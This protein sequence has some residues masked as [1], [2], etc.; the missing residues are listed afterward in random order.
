MSQGKKKRKG[1]RQRSPPVLEYLQ[2]I[3]RKYPDGGQILKEL[4]QNADDA[5]AEEVILFY[6]DRSFGTQRLFS[7][8]L[9]STQGPALLA[10][11]NGIFSEADWKG[12]ESPGI[13][14]KKKDPM[15]VGRFGL[16]F[17][18]VYHMTDFPSILSGEYLL[19]LDTQATALEDGGERWEVDEWEDATDQFQPFWDSLASLGKPCPTSEGYFPGTLFRFPLRQS[20]SK[21]SENLYSTER[22]RELLL[23]FLNDAPISLLFLRNVRKVT[24]GLIGSDGTIT[25]LLR[26]ETTT[27]PLNGPGR[28]EDATSA[29]LDTTAH[30]KKLALDGTTVDKQAT[31]NEWLVLTAEAKRDAYPEL[32]VLAENVSSSPTLSLAYCLQGK[33][34]GRLSC[35]LPLPATEENLTGLPAH[36]SGP[37]QLTDDRRHVQ[38]S[39]EGSQARG[40]DGRWNHLL[41]EEMLPA[42]YCQ[43]ALQAV[44][45]S[46]DPYGAWP[47]PGQSQQ[48]RYKPLIAEICR[49][50]MDVKLLV[51]VGGGIPR[52]LHPREAIL[53][54]ENVKET[55]MGLAVEK[56]LSLAGT[57]LAE[58]PVHVRRALALGA[59]NGPTV[60]E[61]TTKFVRET[62]R[63]ATNIWSQLSL[64]EKK[65]LLEYVVGDEC[66]QELNGLPLLPMT[67]GHFTCFGASGETVFVEN[68]SFPRVL[69]PGLAHRFLP[70]NLNPGLLEHLKAIAKNGIFQNLLSLNQNIIEQNLR[71]SLPKHWFSSSSSPVSWCPK[72]YSQPP[73]EWLTAFWSFLSRHTPSLAP[74]RECPLIP[75]TP[76][77]ASDNVIKLARLLPQ[78]T[79]LFQSHNGHSLPNEV[80]GILEAL[81][82]TVIKTWKPDWC[83]QQLREYI[84]EPTPSSVLKVFAH[85]GVASV[86][87]CLAF[88]PEWQIQSLSAFLS[89]AASLSQKEIEVL[90][91][92]PLFFKMPSLLPPSSPGLVPA[93]G[94]LALEKHLVPSVPTDL[95][96]PEPVLLC[97]SEAERRL[98][99]QIQGSL[100]D[101]PDLCLLCVKAMGKGAYASRAQDAKRF[102]L[103]VLHNG[104]SLF[105]QSRELQALC[106]DL[107][108][109]DCE[110]GG[111][112]RP[113]DLYDPQNHTLRALLRSSKF[114]A[115]P[116]LE[117]AVLRILRNLGLK[118][119][120][121]SISPADAL[122]AAKE[123]SQLQ[124]EVVA[125][126]K[127]QA[128]I[129]V[130]NETP[131]LSKLSCRE[132]KELRS[133]LWVPAINSSKLV[134]AG[135]FWAPESLCSE[136]YA[137]LVGLV[138][139]LTNAFCP[140]AASKLGLDHPPASEKV[141]EN[142]VC[143]TQAYCP[144]NTQ[145]L[146]TTLHSIYRHMQQHLSDFKTPPTVPSVWNGRGFS[147]PEEAVLSYPNGLDLKDLIPQVPPE[148]QQNSRLFVAWGV[149]Q[150]PTPEDVCQALH[151]LADQINAQPQG[152]TQA[153]LLLVTAALDWLC[154]QDHRGE[155]EMPVPVR[156]PELAG[157]A[158]RPISSV[159]YCDMDRA[160]LVELDGDPP[161]LVHELV[162]SATA[163]F[164]GIEM[165][166]KRLSGL[167]LFEAWG[168]S[169]P[170]TLRIRNILREYSQDAD[171]FQELLQNAEDA[172]A[173]TCR[174]LVDVRQHNGTTEGLLDPGMA[175]CQGPALWAQNDALFSKADFTNIVQLGAATKERQDDKIGS[176]GLGFCTVYH[177]TDIPSL[178]SGHTMLIFDPNVTHLQKHIRSPA[179]PG[180]RLTLTPHV[181]TM[182]PEQ[183]RP[184]GGIFGCRPGED[185]S[186]TLLRLPFRTEQEAKD[187]QICPEPFGPRRIR[188]LQ[189]GFREMYQHLLIFLRKVQE[190][191]LTHLPSGSS[192]PE[193]AQP[194]ATVKREKLDGMGN[195]N[196][197]RLTATWESEGV[198][199]YYLLHSCSAK[200]E[201]QELF[202]QGGKEGLHFSPPI[203]AVAL[204]LCPATAGGRWVPGVHGFQGR[205]FCF[206]PLPIESGLP[207]HLTAAFA[208]LSNRKGLW[209]ATEKGKWNRALLRDSVLGAWLGALSQLRDL[210]K[211]GLL[212]DYKYYTFWPDVRSAKHPFSEAAKAFYQALINGIDGEQ[213]VL[214]SDGK[215]WCPARHA[216]ILAAD[217]ICEKQ[218][219]PIAA[220]IFPLLLPEPQIAVSL[221]SWVETNFEACTQADVLLPNT[222]TWAR[223]LRELVLPNLAQLEAPDRDALLLRALDMNDATVDKIL[224]SLPC[225]PTTPKALL[226]NI[227]GLVHPGGPV[228]PLYTPEDGRFPM[229][230]QFVQPQ[231]LLRLEHLGM[232]KDRVAIEEL[233]DRA[234]TVA[235]L[236][237]HDQEEACKR[238]RCI[239]NLL[240]KHVQESFNNTTQ[241]VF[242]EIPF[243]PAVCPGNVKKLC[244]PREIYHHKLQ[245]VVGLTKP[246]LDKEALGK[247]FKI[248]NELKEFLGLN[249]QPP[250]ATV[251]KQLEAV[252]HCSNA[253]NRTMLSTIAM[254]CYA[255]LDKM[256]QE[257]PSCRMEVSQKALTFPFVLVGTH[258]VSVYKV[259][260]NL[261]FDGAP[262]L[263]HLPEEYKQH[264]QLWKW[265]GLQDAFRV[266]DYATVLQDLAKSADGQPLPKGHLGL[267][268]RLITIGLMEA[269]PEGQELDSYRAQGI[270]FPD[271]GKVLHPLT[272]LL[273]DDTPWLPCEN[274]MLLCHT[275]I[276]REIATRCGIPTTK[277]RILS[278]RRIEGLSL[279]ATDFGAKEDLCT[280]LSNILRDYS[281]SQDVLKELLQN[282]DDA[283]A[284]VVHLVWDQ[285]QHPTERS[286]SDEWHVL[287]GP[288]LCIYNDRT[289]EMSDLEGIQRLGSG[290]KGR[291]RDATGKYGLGFNTVFHLTDCPAFIT[292]DS[293]L[294]VFDP[295]LR[296]LPDSDDISPGGKYS[297]TKDFKDA[298]LDIYNAFLP[299]M[300]DLQRG[301]VFR[302]PLRTLANA[303]TSPIWKTPVSE[304]DME[305]MM[306][307]LKK[308][309]DCLVMFLNHVRSIVFS[310]ISKT[311]GTPKEVL[312]V[313]TEGG[314][315]ERLEYQEHLKQAA[316]AGSMDEGRPQRVFYKMKVESSFSNAPSN[317]LVGRQIGVETTD[318]VE[319]T[320]LP[321]GGVAACLNGQ[322]PGRAF[323]TLPLPVTTGLPIHINGNFEVDSSRRDLR[324]DDGQGN[325]SAAWNRLLLRSLVAPLYCQLLEELCQALGS[326][327]LKFD[328]LTSCSEELDSKYLWYFPR[329]TEDVS[330]PWQELVTRV[331]ELAYEEHLPLVPVYQKQ[332]NYVHNVKTEVIVDW[333]TPKLGHPIRDPYFLQHEITDDWLEKTLQNLGMQLVPAFVHLQ[334][335]HSEFL[336]AKVDVLTLDPPSVC[337]F[338]KNLPDL[339]LPCPIKETPMKTTFNCC[340]LLDFC[341]SELSLEDISCVEGL[342]LLV[343]KDDMLRCF[344]REEPVYQSRFSDLFPYHQDRFFAHFITEAQQLIKMEFMKNFTLSESVDY[345][346]EMLA[347]DDWAN[348]TQRN[349]WLREMWNFFETE[350]YKSEDEMNQAFA[351]LLSLFKGCAVLP[352]CG[353]SRRLV[354]LDG[355]DT[356][357]RDDSSEVS[358]ILYKLGFTMLDS[359]LLPP[360]LTITCIWPRLLKTKSPAVVLTQLSAHSS[361]CWD[362]LKSWDFYTLLN[363]LIDNLKEIEGD[364]KLLGKL[365]AL[366][367][368]QTH[369]GKYVSLTL[370][371]NVYRLESKISKE[372]KT[373]KE[374]YEV[375]RKTLFLCDNWVNRSLSKLLGIDVMNDLQQ[376]VQQLLPQLPC[377]PEAR[378][379]QAVKLLLIIKNHYSQEYGAKKAVIVSKFQSIAFIRDMENELHPASYF[380]DEDEVLF[381]ELGL[382]S[383][384]VPG[385]F[386]ESVGLSKYEVKRFLCDVG[387]QKVITEEDFLECAAKV[388]R[389]AR[390]EGA[391]SNNLPKRRKALWKHLLSRSNETLSD[392]FLNKVSKIHFLA[393]RSIS[394]DLCCLHPPY[395]PCSAPVAPKDSLYTSRS[396]ELFWTSAVAL[397]WTDYIRK[398]G[399]DTLKRLGV[400]CTLPAQLVLANLS[401]V[402]QASCIT[403]E[404]RATRAKVL[405]EMYRFLSEEK[406][407]DADCLKG[408]PV[409]LV[410]NEE[411][412]EAQNVVV[413]LKYPDDFRPY[414]YK[415]PTKLG[416][417][418]DLF[419]KFGVQTDPSIYHYAN[420]LAQ[421]H[422]ETAERKQ[423]QPNLTKTIL[424]ATELL[425][426]LLDETKKPVNFT[427]L[428][429]LYLPCIDGK[430]YPSNTLVFSLY[431]SN[432]ESEALQKNFHILKDFSLYDKCKQWRLL[433]LLPEALRPKNL[434]DITQEQ[435]EESSLKLCHYGEHCESRSSLKELLISHE[436]QWAFVAL[437]QWQDPE[438]PVETEE[439]QG[440]WDKC[441]SPEQLEVVCYEK[442]CT[443][444][445]HNSQPL[446]GTQRDKVAHAVMLPNDRC[447]VYLKHQDRLEQP[448]IVHFADILAKEVN[449]LLGERLQSNAVMTVLMKI[450]VCQEPQ[451]IAEVL[452]DNQVPLHQ[453]TYQSA[454]NLPPAGEEIPEEWYDSLEMNIVHTFV[455]GDYVGYLDSSQLKERYLYAVVLEALGLQQ[456]GGGHIRMYRVDLG[457]GRKATVSTYDIYHFRR[458]KQVND[459]NK[460]LVLAENC[461]SAGSTASLDAD[462]FWYQR[463]LS[464]VKKEV[465][466]HLAEIWCL[467]VEEKKK[468]VR[469][470]Y[471]CYHPDKNVGQEELANEIFKYLK[472][473]IQEMENKYKP[474]GSNS[475]KK[476]FSQCWSEW[477]EQA[478]RHHRSRQE[479]T[480]QRWGKGGGRRGG[481]GGGGGGG[482]DYNYNFWSFHQSQ[483]K[484][485]S[486]RLCGEEAKRWLRQAEC[487]LKAAAGV[488]GNGSTEW[489]LYMTYRAVEKA[490]TAVVYSE[491]GKFDKSQSLAMLANK[492]ASWGD[493]LEELPDQID[494]LRDHGVDDKTTQYPSYHDLPTIPNEAFEACKEKDVLLSARK[495][496]NTVKKW[497]GQ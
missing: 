332:I 257:N 195:L 394:D 433:R 98:I 348:D 418:V 495:I 58:A 104:D 196:I 461:P 450:L 116:F 290:G 8:G 183:F 210:Y 22:V 40:A 156:I 279:W 493:E 359:S 351:E 245:A 62:L 432:Q 375:D 43:M 459:L 402:C 143:L 489:L 311:G 92:L 162:S 363:F 47:D 76:L 202:E 300:F 31:S 44:G 126:A 454:W 299:D 225:I 254:K 304:E 198:T 70:Q 314:E 35:V 403:P 56:A 46:S 174:F 86:T 272:K 284:S 219:S 416:S 491:G 117:P 238:I 356:I 335:I 154:A 158:L 411:I 452:K 320:L 153:E 470:L 378:V 71:E 253:M 289:F 325:A 125:D 268:I 175:A 159:L 232:I 492:V 388:E 387:L 323:C 88:L 234:K 123:V 118:S 7:E 404:T 337:H 149:R 136:Q 384:F 63:R 17:N 226:K 211:E 372:S 176:F 97:R 209:D 227:K 406:E 229:G 188:A 247:G 4:I 486:R 197:V 321:H 301:T 50:L 122:L 373:F 73:L 478:H 3:L 29:K 494:E 220:R 448:K 138:M 464:E 20:P 252:S 296:Y 281:S 338:L 65:L 417:Y 446:E 341:L 392:A 399:K 342:P 236:W 322:P 477:N 61:A 458:N 105:S 237:H 170:V 360:K 127:S 353:C 365:K 207:L 21:I 490:L 110:S 434:S 51:R 167:E 250:V 455:P 277:R 331:Y 55:P 99:I 431:M 275:M 64:L 274:G 168:P 407:I 286:F 192:S 483:S 69:L 395:V 345:I 246:V 233:I 383:R 124:E 355:L 85:L 469:R 376:F 96:T 161:L 309:A 473:K 215:K 49:K 10:Y 223:F 103:W 189:A 391:T 13:S 169:E 142:L 334:G 109:V 307:A 369:Q 179:N 32:W 430:L 465:D 231:R 371:D 6:D 208:V 415:L 77:H 12:I 346:Q 262:Y 106:R 54:P 243:L 1:F 42:S 258:F 37:F 294:C 266:E 27:N 295:T 79:L 447:Q 66:Y 488:A 482:G 350:I 377:L 370:Y 129:Q 310:V 329:V 186:G 80:S 205:A 385:K 441:F 479:F 24:L 408:L 256:V 178:L 401:N 349:N 285:R 84:L 429:E 113:T 108:F 471:L 139:G 361:L 273:F 133:L 148:F 445:V 87:S 405:K 305:N 212:E 171:V 463:P 317:W 306:E 228:A 33:C 164:L 52:F 291:R 206:L 439:I 214:F 74:F 102:M 282:A 249:R 23:A 34:V 78:S 485:Q 111:L 235:A 68:Q 100:L 217:V 422:E 107:P 298:F 131:L 157:F 57:L 264:K 303:V 267:V 413:L 137:P 19:V 121:S 224:T 354:P 14:H 324:K 82:C 419:E 218:L 141:M 16:G 241:A 216:C 90:K 190:V 319:S 368:F 302:L 278:R 396:V 327:P 115:G 89:T 336:K 425:F 200:A 25:E 467:S 443:I 255:F 11:N 150:S 475:N 484:Y 420:V 444:R 287:Q 297:L 480:K 409:V 93:R 132:L 265:V 481:G 135:R 398:D 400:L 147:L 460:S 91:E 308:E 438:T 41:M 374:L 442:V 146:T 380:Y 412:A 457:R 194:L 435:L 379:L 203:A 230:E 199:S 38:W 165:L 352:V 263:F 326:T 114:P 437:L 177:I 251:L 134:A 163:A 487:D 343:T 330:P 259:A 83:H 466:A 436:F 155:G 280:R 426:Q 340:V 339:S 440:V 145:E 386:Y 45:H 26:A 318:I 451:E 160:R 428:K 201:A 283:G 468:A 60:Q 185:Y 449:R 347:L 119:D 393:S 221:P 292:G 9:E 120:L 182:F 81:G 358:K 293:A 390:R 362:K 476:N 269:L 140:Q 472:E 94:Y 333:S 367:V 315:P 184:F 364:H 239:L 67:N 456:S 453:P 101:T 222:Y 72:E 270:F 191:S 30:I 424:K 193:N 5:G 244:C 59:G 204:P 242:R 48:L 2:G 180:I 187:S 53:L 18:S 36:I 152:G 316:A 276:P 497:L 381:E 312:R 397:P 261:P 328:S 366:P 144:T 151:N 389:E 28:V 496:L 213:P 357:V 410:D 172:G 75:L 421:I 166:S 240:N 173:Q 313:K 130:C 271:Q 344:S 382:S 15:T 474:G 288:A 414:L 248:S 128:L 427:E 462:S 423:L 95:L 112:G 39:E 181:A 260:Y